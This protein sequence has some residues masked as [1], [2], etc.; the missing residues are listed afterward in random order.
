MLDLVAGVVGMA[1]CA[2]PPEGWHRVT[3]LG[4]FMWLVPPLVVLFVGLYFALAPRRFRVRVLRSAV[5]LI[6]T[7]VVAFF[8]V[9][10]A[11]SCGRYA[12]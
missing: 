4:D 9:A 10:T 1:A 8:T 3:T 7:V 11:S 5:V 2:A 6:G 12:P